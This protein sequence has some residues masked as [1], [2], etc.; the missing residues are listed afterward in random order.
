M[1]IR[2]TNDL[3]NLHPNEWLEKFFIMDVCALSCRNIVRKCCCL[4][5]DKTNIA[6][7]DKEKLANKQVVKDKE[8]VDRAS[9]TGILSRSPI[10]SSELWAQTLGITMKLRTGNIENLF[11]TA[12][13]TP[14]FTLPLISSTKKSVICRRRL[15]ASK[16]LPQ[17]L[18]DENAIVNTHD[19]RFARAFWKVQNTC[20]CT[21]YGTRLNF[22]RIAY[23]VRTLNII[24]L[25]V[26]VWLLA[27]RA[28]CFSMSTIKLFD[29]EAV[30]NRFRSYWKPGF[31]SRSLV[32]E[33]N[34]ARC[35]WH[36]SGVCFCMDGDRH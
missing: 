33:F 23:L 27:I 21:N 16:L 11:W 15:C 13:R 30:H 8:Q 20:F 6:Y 36:S 7:L 10:F 35:T 14:L 28:L 32:Y 1:K 17:I 26:M 18:S 9:V 12:E 4:Y 5:Y 3:V 24:L 19:P 25:F 29:L 34:I 22:F 31:G 2:N